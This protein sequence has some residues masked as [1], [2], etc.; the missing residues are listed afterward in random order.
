[1]A[2]HV[3]EFEQRCG[4]C[5]GRGR[6]YVRHETDLGDFGGMDFG[7]WLAGK[8]FSARP[9]CRESQCPAWW[10]QCRVGNKA[11]RWPECVGAG[12]TFA[13]CEHFSTH[14]KCWARWDAEFADVAEAT[15]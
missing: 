11:P 13:R 10:Y 14:A 8:P 15:A 4:A 6:I 2:K 1:M 5:K 9:E 12:G 3:I 7:S